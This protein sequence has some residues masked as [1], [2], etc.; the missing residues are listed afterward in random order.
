MTL[1]HT[2]V[3]NARAIQFRRLLNSSLVRGPVCNEDHVQ[4]AA[5]PSTWHGWNVSWFVSEVGK[6]I[7]TEVDV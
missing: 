2:T 3:L 7:S 5:W 6:Y 4:G 1:E